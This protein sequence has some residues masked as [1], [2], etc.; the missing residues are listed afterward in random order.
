[1]F[2]ISFKLEIL[3]QQSA[4]CERFGLRSGGYKGMPYIGKPTKDQNIR[5]VIVRFG[6]HGYIVRYRVLP[7]DDAIFVTRIW[8]GR[9]A[10]E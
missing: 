4:P 7:P 6:R 3:M 9:E 2:A 10:R 5:Q 8:H 1:M